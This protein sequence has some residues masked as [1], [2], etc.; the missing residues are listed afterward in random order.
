VSREELIFCHHC[1][2]HKSSYVIAFCHFDSQRH[3]VLYPSL[4]QVNG[5]QTYNIDPCNF[6]MVN[7]FLRRKRKVEKK[8]RKKES[9]DH[10][11]QPLLSCHRAFCSFCLK[12]SYDTLLRDAQENPDWLCPA[13]TG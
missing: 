9:R 11:R 3:G 2:Q 1:K 4:V 5:V 7:L 12:T 8:R 6:E 10:E 13:C